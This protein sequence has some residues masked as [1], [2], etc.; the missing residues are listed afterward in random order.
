MFHLSLPVKL[1]LAA[2]LVVPAIAYSQQTSVCSIEQLTSASG[3]D[4][5]FLNWPEINGDGSRVTWSSMADLTEQNADAGAELFLWEAGEGIRQLTDST[6]T[7]S[8]A[9][10]AI[11]LSGS[12]IVFEGNAD[13]VPGS[14]LDGNFE[15]FLWDEQRGILQITD[16]EFGNPCGKSISGDGNRVF[17]GL[18]NADLTGENP[19]SNWELY[20]YDVDSKTIIQVTSSTGVE[21]VCDG[22]PNNDGSIVFFGSNASLGLP[23]P[24][25]N[26]EIYRWEAGIGIDAITATTS[27][28]SIDPRTNSDGRLAVFASTADLVPGRNADGNREV[29][30][31]SSTEGFQQLTQ[32][33]V[34]DASRPDISGDGTRIAFSHSADITGDNPQQAQQVFLWEAS[35]V[36]QITQIGAGE[37]AAGLPSLDFDGTHIAFRTRAELLPGGNPEE[38]FEI[39]LAICPRGSIT[40]VPVPILSGSKLAML[41][42]MLGL[43]AVACRFL[44]QAV[45]QPS[46]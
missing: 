15:E 46:A 6:A 17:F 36:R 33:L 27:G 11:D 41:A 10:P 1:F 39:Y 12:V 30:L 4:T 21:G 24:E 23:N 20:R 19:D 14:N 13:L 38:D 40:P 26:S 45:I 22:D 28:N 35:S 29:F 7:F 44:R 34:G 3:A 9:Q 16:T 43:L 25:L 2:A 42:L 5:G 32:T 37:S 8:A 18:S 31:W